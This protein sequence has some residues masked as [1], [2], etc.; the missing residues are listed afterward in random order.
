MCS[1]PPR[2]QGPPPADPLGL[3]S[4]LCGCSGREQTS[5]LVGGDHEVPGLR[6][7]GPQPSDLGLTSVR[8]CSGS[9]PCRP[10]S[11]HLPSPGPL[12]RR[13]PLEGSQVSQPAPRALE[14]LHALGPSQAPVPPWGQQ[15]LLELSLP[16]PLRCS[17][18]PDPK[19][20]AGTPVLSNRQE[21]PHLPPCACCLKPTPGGIRAP[22]G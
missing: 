20:Q 2:V 22:A 5:G 12:L 18:V 8:E 19:D 1:L 21:D 9:A 15:S 4:N 11:P 6:T 7:G 14:A 10:P 3:W 16:N 13:Q 17:G